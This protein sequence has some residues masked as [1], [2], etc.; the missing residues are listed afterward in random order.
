[1]DARDGGLIRYRGHFID[2]DVAAAHD[3]LSGLLAPHRLTPLFRVSREGTEIHLVCRT[4]QGE[5][6]VD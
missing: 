2:E 4:A 5:R 1:M 3:Q 6:M